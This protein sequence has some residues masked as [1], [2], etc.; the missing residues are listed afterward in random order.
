MV[1]INNSRVMERGDGIEKSKSCREHRDTSMPA[2]VDTFLMMHHDG[3]TLLTLMD[4]GMY[5]FVILQTID[6]C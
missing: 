2:D 6:S 5:E 4:D 1:N 3:W